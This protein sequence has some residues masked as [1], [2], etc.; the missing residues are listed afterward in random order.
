M[1]WWKNR[2]AV[3]MEADTGVPAGGAPAAPATAA[4]AAPASKPDAEALARENAELKA[5]LA[6]HEAGDVDDL[7]ARARADRD[8]RDA[9]NSNQKSLENAIA[10]NYT[11]KEFLKHNAALLPS[12]VTDLFATADRE[13]FD[14]PIEKASELKSGVIKEFFQIQSNLDLLTAG[15]K[16]LLAD[17]LKLT[18]NGRLEKAQLTYDTI[19][20]PALETLRRVKK[21]EEVGRARM[22]YGNDTDNRA[23]HKNKLIALSKNHYLGE[24]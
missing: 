8:A 4:P 13:T 18:K 1:L 5:L 10:F 14:S 6:K 11:S 23:A 19:F 24:K 16:T 12:T 20:E 3:L 21:A 22:G 2:L 15:Q 17:F 9:G 7:A